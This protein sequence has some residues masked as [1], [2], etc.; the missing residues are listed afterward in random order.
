MLKPRC[1]ASMFAVGTMVFGAGAVSGHIVMESLA[2]MGVEVVGSTPD[3]LAKYIGSELPKRVR[4]I[5][6]SAAR[7]A[8]NPPH[9]PETAISRR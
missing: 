6:Q 4:V 1:I 9:N 3:R 5:K 8:W 7:V 2:G